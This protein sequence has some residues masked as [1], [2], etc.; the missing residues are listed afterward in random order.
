[1]SS[2]AGHLSE[3]QLRFVVLD[4]QPEWPAVQIL[5]DG[6]EAFVDQLPG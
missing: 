2:R 5:V 1:M 6:R 3:L 4:G